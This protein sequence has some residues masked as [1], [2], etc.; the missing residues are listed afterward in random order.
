MAK[1]QTKSSSIL[2]ISD[3]FDMEVLQKIQDAF[4]AATGVAAIIVDYKGNPVL[5]YSNFTDF[6]TNIRKIPECYEHCMRSDADGGIESVRT[7]KPAIYVCHGG[8]VDMAVPIMAKGNYIGA[9][10]AGQVQIPKEEMAKLP[11][12]S[13][14][15]L[16][17]L[18]GRQDLARMRSQVTM[19]TLERVQAAAD[20][21]FTIANYLVE[22]QLIVVM[23][24]E[25]NEA[26]MELMEE[27]NRRSDM[28]SALQKANLKA[29][30][31]QINPHFFFNVLN[32]IGR[33][34]M[35]EGANQT[36]DMVYRFSDLLRYTM[37]RDE[38]DFVT[39]QEEIRHVRNY[40]HIQKVR[41]G[42]RLTYDFD[43]S[44]ELKTVLC[45]F[46]SIQP[47][48]ENAIKYAVEARENGAHISVSAHLS[49]NDVEIHVIDNG[50]G[51]AS[52]RID[53]L[54]DEERHIESKKGMGIGIRNTNKRLKYYY[55]PDY[56]VTFNK[57]ITSGTDVIITIP[58][59]RMPGTAPKK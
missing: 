41:Q 36:Q 21:L 5:E 59:K 11:M 1:T 17:N 30:Q 20:L 55:G 22:R 57:N 54:L 49:G 46:M 12:G 42:D 9:I 31:A 28:E 47:F 3:V 2:S 51:I 27:I 26:N 37:R 8:L 40:L 52:E 45:P 32:T 16:T 18:Y 4:S 33:L 48:V 58:Q 38:N 24:R 19:T 35:I 10:L 25:L 50:V 34:A 6:C 14:G 56:G 23:Q 39:L 13:P 43:I 44:K 15:K 29:L 7:G 53:E